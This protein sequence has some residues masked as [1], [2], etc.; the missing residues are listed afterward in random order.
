VFRDNETPWVA[1]LFEKYTPQRHAFEMEQVSAYPRGYVT[2][3]GGRQIESALAGHE[4]VAPTF[5]TT[6]SDVEYT[7]HVC[8]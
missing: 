2:G 5:A 8:V 1:A 4:S 7:E 3:V 6:T